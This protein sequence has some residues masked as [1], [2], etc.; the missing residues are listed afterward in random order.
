MNPT[1]TAAQ[2][3]A[4]ET[5]IAAVAS[6]AG[7]DPLELDTPLYDAIE[8]DELDAIVGGAGRSTVEVTFR[9]YG[10]TVTVDS[11]LTVTLSE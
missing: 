6:R 8:P 9:Y 7:V 4:S 10:Y 5:V 11:D 2:Q 1:A 3:S